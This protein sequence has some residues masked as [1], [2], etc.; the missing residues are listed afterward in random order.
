MVEDKNLDK[1]DRGDR[2][3]GSTGISEVI[4]ND[5]QTEPLNLVIDVCDTTN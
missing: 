3:F 5:V 2:G 4:V 1:T